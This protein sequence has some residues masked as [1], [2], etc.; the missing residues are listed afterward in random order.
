M[1]Q[2]PHSERSVRFQSETPQPIQVKLSER[3][4]N[5]ECLTDGKQPTFR[6][7]QASI[8][9]RLEINADHYWSERARMALVW[10]HTSSTAME[11]LEP[12]YLAES[13]SQRF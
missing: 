9:D 1:S 11:Y 6:Q 8:T 7:W 4:P 5:I 10:G 13:D 2:Q 3:T 12:Q